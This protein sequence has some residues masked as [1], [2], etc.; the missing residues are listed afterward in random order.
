ML[1]GRQRVTRDTQP[2]TYTLPRHAITQHHS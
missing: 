2:T 1:F